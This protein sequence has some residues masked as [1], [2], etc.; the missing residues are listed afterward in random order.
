[1]DATARL[2]ENVGG[3]HGSSSS[4]TWP[5]PTRNGGFRVAYMA[6]CIGLVGLFGC[7]SKEEPS[8]SVVVIGQCDQTTVHRAYEDRVEIEAPGCGGIVLDN[9]QLIGSG[10]LSQEVYTDGKSIVVQVRAG[11]TGGALRAVHWSGTWWAAGESPPMIWKQGYQSWSA[12]GV[13]PLEGPMLF[14]A[15]GIPTFGGDDGVLEVVEETPWS[16][17]WVGAAGRHEGGSVALGVTR[18]QSGKFVASFEANGGVHAVWGGGQQVIVLE[19]GEVVTLDPMWMGVGSEPLA[20]LENYAD[21]ALDGREVRSTIDEVPPTGWSS[22][23]EYYS[24]LTEEHVRSNLAAALEINATSGL[25]DIEVL[26]LDDGWQVAWGEWTANEKFPSGMGPLAE[27]IQAAGLTPGLWMAPFYVDE[28]S[29][30]VSDNPDWWVRDADGAVIVIGGRAVIDATHPAALAWMATQV[31]DRVDEGWVYLKLDFLFAGAI[32]GTR[33]EVVTGMEAYHIGMSAIREAAGDAWILACGAPMLPTIGYAD[34]YRTGPD[35]AFEVAPDPN[36]DHLRNQ[37][38]Y[39]AARNWT[40]GRWWWVDA[41]SVMLRE[42]ATEA[43]VRGAAVANAV[44]G[45][46]YLLGD[47]M[48]ALTAS[49]LDDG[50]DLDLVSLRGAWARPQDIWAHPSGFDTSPIIE[51]LQQDDEVPVLWTFPDGSVAVLNLSGE[52]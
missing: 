48:G 8:E 10:D 24:G 29:A 43:Q 7:K 2:D 41:D 46:A 5:G 9:Y 49:Q 51:G 14:D 39:T 13:F 16:S 11:D 25:A 18:A 50:F 38:R 34:S 22:W 31:S 4:S 42:P 1:M 35:M 6:V 33:S 21:H 20:L 26:Q 15:D 45:G 12:S 52:A 37:A 17:W 23:T 36:L 44:S 47:D 30:I 19:P 3:L 40:N 28:N 32:E 27:D